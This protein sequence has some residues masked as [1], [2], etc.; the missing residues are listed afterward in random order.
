[1]PRWNAPKTH[2]RTLMLKRCGP[3]C[4]LDAPRYPVCVRR[5]CRVSKRGVRAAYNRSRQMHERKLSLK[6]KRLLK[7]NAFKKN[8]T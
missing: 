8:K 7:S 6:A 4:F 3:Q 2:E 1:M 5:T